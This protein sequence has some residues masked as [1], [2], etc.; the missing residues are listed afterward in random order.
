MKHFQTFGGNSNLLLFVHEQ[1]V[2]STGTLNH[3]DCTNLE[4]SAKFGLVVLYTIQN[5]ISEG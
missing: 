5:N 3:C 2:G 4:E 1:S